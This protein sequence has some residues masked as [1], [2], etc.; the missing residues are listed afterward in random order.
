MAQRTEA[1][2]DHN[3][4]NRIPCYGMDGLLDFGYG[5]DHT[6]DLGSV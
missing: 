6:A 1:K 5:S 2:E 4:R 3:R